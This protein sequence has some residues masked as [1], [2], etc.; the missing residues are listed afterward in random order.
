[1]LI[2]NCYTIISRSRCWW[3]I[4][5]DLSVDVKLSYMRSS[6]WTVSDLGGYVAILESCQGEMSVE[7]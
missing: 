2:H 4:G 1:M 3:Q 6:M 7:L 5:W